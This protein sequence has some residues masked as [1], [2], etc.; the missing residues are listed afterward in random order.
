[1]PIRIVPRFCE[2]GYGQFEKLVHGC[3]KPSRW[4]KTDV[5]ANIS[6]LRL[7]IGSGMLRLSSGTLMLTLKTGGGVDRVVRGVLLGPMR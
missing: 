2:R 4:E 3:R 7:N 6:M 5:V 1:M